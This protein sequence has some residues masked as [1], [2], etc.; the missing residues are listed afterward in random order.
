[1]LLSLNISEKSFG[2]KILYTGLKFDI[3]P[4]EKVGLIGRNGTG[5]STLLH[6]ITGEDKDFQGE[7]NVKQNTVVIASRQEHHGHEAKSVLEYI[8]GDLPEFEK[9]HHIL[10]TYPEHMGDDTRKMQR[11]SDA[12]ERFS[13]LGYF[14]IEDELTQ[15][16]NDY[17]LDPAKLDGPLSELSGGQKR[18]VELIKVQRARGHLALIDEPTN[19]MDYVA[20]QAF[21]KWFTSTDEAVMVITHD[22]DVLH[23]VDKIV[24]IRDG[25]AYSFKG[26]YKQYLNINKNQITSQ[27][28]E[29]DLVQRRIQ[30]L[31]ND[32]IRFRRM[33]EKARDPGTIKRFKSQEMRASA[34]LAKLSRSEKPS[35]WIDRESAEDLNPKMTGAYAKYKAK[36][37]QLIT[38]SEDSRSSRLLVETRGLS[39]GY[40][41]TPLFKDINLSLHEGERIRLHGRNGAGKTT[42]V[43]AII[44]KARHTAA[45]AKVFDGT[46]AVEKDLNIG[47][48]EQEIDTKFLPMKLK[49]AIEQ[50]HFD[51]DVPVSDQK[52]KQLLGEY[53]FNPAT[54]GDTPIERLSGGQKA[55]F[56]LIRMLL[57]NPLLLVLDEPTNHLDLPSIEELEDAL[58]KY[59]GAVIYISHDSFFAEKVGGD[60]I[61]VGS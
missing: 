40:G 48:Y 53:L 50:S 37:I 25:R 14:Q 11:Y 54:D 29:Y 4:G 19:H 44:A 52:V 18:M 2:D 17:Q 22:R 5:K 1:M 39:L 49:D 47:L 27:V 46:V 21:I 23:H 33:K 16:F 58:A 6:L 28:N 20:K 3:Q 43:N 9:L 41:D 34:E 13:Q 51:K 42:L 32:V 24:E 57:S 38:K 45:Q 8:Q 59:H 12:L 31:T 15:A 61:P 60:T 35:F 30:N 10:Q 56:Q 7:V 55:R 36:N 26:N